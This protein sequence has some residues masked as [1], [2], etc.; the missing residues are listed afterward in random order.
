MQHHYTSSKTFCDSL[1]SCAIMATLSVEKSFAVVLNVSMSSPY[2]AN[3]AV[4]HSSESTAVP[5]CGVP[6]EES[7]SNFASCA[8]RRRVTCTSRGVLEFSAAGVAR[9]LEG[10]CNCRESML[11]SVEA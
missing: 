2:S 6:L 8:T 5:R 10:T 1:S 4:S 7:L 11:V 9:V 3:I